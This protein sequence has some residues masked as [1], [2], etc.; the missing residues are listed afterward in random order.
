[1]SE[2]IKNI[3]AERIE[4]SDVVP[5]V[6]RSAYSSVGLPPVLDACCGGRNFWFDK[7]DGRA[8]F[9]DK[10]RERH[11]L[12]YPSGNYVENI[13]PD[14]LGDFSKMRFPDNT[15]ALVVF[16]PPHIEQKTDSGR[17]VKKYGKL[18]GDWRTMLREGFKECFRVLRPEGV[19]IFKWCEVRIPVKEIL[20]MT[21]EKPL[22][23]HRSGKAAKTHWIAFIKAASQPL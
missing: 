3:T 23:G 4:R 17:I 12:H 11:E 6:S 5:I 21:N 14:E 16:D 15:F 9:V 7:K 22:F 8:L 2:T 13:D 10:R 19:L 18:D 1:V 20:A